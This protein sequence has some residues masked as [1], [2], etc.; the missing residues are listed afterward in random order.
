MSCLGTGPTSRPLEAPSNL[1]QRLAR[2]PATLLG[3]NA[4]EHVFPNLAVPAKVDQDCLLSTCT[5]ENKVNAAKG[6]D[7]HDPIIGDRS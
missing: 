7:R 1:S 5:V 4:V 3:H 2:L 6:W